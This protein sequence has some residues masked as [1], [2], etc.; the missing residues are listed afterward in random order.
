MHHHLKPHQIVIITVAG[1][2]T[3]A[4]IMAI[5]LG[6]DPDADPRGRAAGA[7]GAVIAS[8]MVLALVVDAL[9]RAVLSHLQ[10]LRED[11]HQLV[12]LERRRIHAE[13]LG[14]EADKAS[15]DTGPMQT[16]QRLN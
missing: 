16:N 9:G 4:S 11:L 8:V 14:M 3:V 1:I 15:G 12:E 13:L 2:I 5:L 10:P 7:A 6:D